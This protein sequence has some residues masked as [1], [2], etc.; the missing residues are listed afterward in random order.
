MY[1]HV[2]LPNTPEEFKNLISSPL[3]FDITKQTQSSTIDLPNP[4]LHPS[5]NTTCKCTGQFGNIAPSCQ[6]ATVYGIN[7]SCSILSPDLYPCD[8]CDLKLEFDGV[9][10]GLVRVSKTIYFDIT[11]ANFIQNS[12]VLGPT[13]ITGVFRVLQSVHSAHGSSFCGKDIHLAAAWICLE[14]SSN[15]VFSSFGCCHC[16]SFNEAPIIIG[17]GTK[18]ACQCN[19]HDEPP[20]MV[21]LSTRN[22]IHFDKRVFVSNIGLRHLMLTFCGYKSKQEGTKPI[23]RRQVISLDIHY[24]NTNFAS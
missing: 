23:S 3:Y 6:V 12:I 15:D 2:R 1:S 9:A 22:G 13:S 7:R 17:D 5:I 16:G 18:L 11:L 24:I 20:H 14:R 19:V 8:G 10:H 4:Q 21:Q